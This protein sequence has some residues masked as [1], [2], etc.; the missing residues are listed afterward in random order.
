MVTTSSLRVAADTSVA[1]SNAMIAA[2]SGILSD[3]FKDTPYWWDDASAP[4]LPKAK[5]SRDMDVAVIGS[6][7]TGLNAALETTRAGRST[8]V[9][10]AERAGWGC[11]TRNGGQI[12]TSVKLTVEQ[13]SRRYGAKRA[14][15]IRQEGRTALEWI[16]ELVTREGM[17]CDFKR[18]GR[19]HA[20]HTPEQFTAL[21]RRIEVE[22]R[23][24]IE[25][26]MVPRAE[27]RNEL[28]SDAYHGGAVYPRHAALHPAKYH[29]GLLSAVI[30]AGAQVV[31][32]CPV[33]GIERTAMGFELQ[34]PSGAISARDVI[35]ATNG[36]T[37]ALMPWLRRRVIP[38][39]SYVIA[40]EPLPGDLMDR[41]FPTDRIASDTCRVI[42]YFRA[43]SDRSRIVFGGRVSAGEIDPRVSA[44]LLHAEL[45]RI[46]PELRAT[47][48]SHSWAGTVAYSFDTLAH[49]GVHDGIHYA[50][51]YCGSGVSMAS[52][53][54]MRIAQ[55]L[56]G[57]KEGRTAFD[58]LP[59]PTRPLYSGTPWF[60]P[61]VVAWYRWRD[62]RECARAAGGTGPR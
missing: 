33:L 31:T 24:G 52:Y 17:D 5:P 25:A 53:L 28:G 49:T 61:A 2:K 48:I 40:T 26:H 37:G 38:I 3:G 60:L 16:E 9:L 11:S 21:A 19:F 44:P 54:G 50:A 56:L 43:A 1:R 55:R 51:S 15:A 57:R 13:L 32:H 36:Y 6:G 58:D 23:E 27:Q 62:R 14:Q 41:L 34:T 22:R 39:G 29:A 7:Y 30:S 8:L 35:V 18:N 46:F 45:A 20:A 12:S 59:F 10:D 47:R 42:Y 4:E